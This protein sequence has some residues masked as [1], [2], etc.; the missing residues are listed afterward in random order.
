MEANLSE[1][2]TTDQALAELLATDVLYGSGLANHGPMVVEAL[3]H[4]GQT[5]MTE[6]FMRAYFP[7]LEAKVATAEPPQDWAAFARRELVELVPAAA[8]IAGHGLLRVAHAIRALERTDT[9]TRR[10]DLAEA[11]AY[12][13][14][15]ERIE[16]PTVLQ[17]DVA[18]GDV[19]ARVPRL[20]DVDATGM[21][22]DAL[23]AAASNDDVQAAVRSLAAPVD[24]AVFLRDLALA[25]A[26]RYVVNDDGHSF[27]FIHGV[28]VSMMAQGLLRYLDDPATAQLCAA[29]AGFVIYAIAAYDQ[30]PQDS[31]DVERF[32]SPSVTGELLAAPAAATLDDHTIK[33][34]DA[35]LTLAAETGESLPLHAAATRIAATS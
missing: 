26:D 16:G 20:T 33:F 25:S 11:V 8:A 17:G 28:T 14:Q 32:K 21:L 19:V 35:C 6:P 29:V 2:A 12:W 3:E 5:H 24:A 15:G 31:G 1:V 7:L 34:T 9:S 23:T 27:A 10:A 13:N 18:L 30:L 4:L 22:T